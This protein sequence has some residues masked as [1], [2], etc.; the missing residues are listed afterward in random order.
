[1]EE[2][3][4]HYLVFKATVTEKLNED[5]LEHK[6]YIAEAEVETKEVAEEHKSRGHT[7]R[8]K[9]E[10]N[11][12]EALSRGIVFDH[13]EIL[14][15]SIHFPLTFSFKAPCDVRTCPKTIQRN[16]DLSYVE[17]VDFLAGVQKAYRE[18]QEGN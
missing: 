5:T 10:G 18:L 16:E 9:E 6:E 15:H 4:N 13:S 8:Q 3:N 14:D 17:Q 1:M 12:L 7:V 2:P 11:E